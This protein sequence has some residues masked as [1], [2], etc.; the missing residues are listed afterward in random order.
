MKEERLPGGKVI[1]TNR[2]DSEMSVTPL[3]VGYEHIGYVR[4]D[5]LVALFRLPL[6]KQEW[7][8]RELYA[9]LKRVADYYDHLY[10]GG[11]SFAKRMYGEVGGLPY[12][13]GYLSEA[14]QV[15]YDPKNP[16]KEPIAR[17]LTM[18]EAEKGIDP[19][20]C[21]GIGYDG[22]PGPGPGE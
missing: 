7:V 16:P 20:A 19:R 11:A 2:L 9:A 21:G 13:A 3:V 22:G 14:A 15:D 8:I 18:G 4:G 17:P 12:E 1:K 6:E 5:G 10:D